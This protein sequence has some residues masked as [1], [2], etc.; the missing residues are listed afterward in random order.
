MRAV[1]N[2]WPGLS[3]HDPITGGDGYVSGGKDQRRPDSTHILFTCSF[4]LLP[5]IIRLYSPILVVASGKKT[6]GADGKGPV[7]ASD[8][9]MV[10]TSQFWG[11]GWGQR[12]RTNLIF[13]FLWRPPSA[14]V[15]TAFS[16]RSGVPAAQLRFF[17]SIAFFFPYLA[18][19]RTGYRYAL[20]RTG[21][22]IPIFFSIFRFHFPV[23]FFLFLSM[24]AF[25]DDD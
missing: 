16:V 18:A 2:R 6:T 15:Q 12:E 13:T 11:L 22:A 7:A 8:L 10:V 20:T 1:S 4:G 21:T 23:L 14:R 24:V 3:P 5:P 17:Y 19:I 9:L 25:L